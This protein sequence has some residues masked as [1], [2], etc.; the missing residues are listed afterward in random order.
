MKDLVVLV[1]DKNMEYALK[2][3]LSRPQAL[4]IRPVEY[5]I[6]VHPRRDA[7]CLHEAHDI[8]RRY[9]S[10]CECALVLFD[11]QGCGQEQ[12]LP[13]RLADEV[14]SRLMQ[15]GWLK[16]EA[17]VLA[18]ELEVWVWS[19]SP[20]VAECIGWGNRAP[21]LRQ[22]LADQGHWPAGGLKPPE[23]REALEAALREAQKPR[24][25]ALYLALAQKVSLRGHEEPAF[26]RLTR[27]LGA[28]FPQV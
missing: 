26:R 16:T 17:V 13:D 2:G 23:P 14:R 25:S 7:G 4:G 19:N 8:L 27:A 24:S 15:N 12:E 3:L 22:W 1:A 6:A 9:L 10:A 5:E 28:W 18:P 21:P 20:H 11:H